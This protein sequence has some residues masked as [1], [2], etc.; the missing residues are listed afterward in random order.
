MAT[1]STILLVAT[2]VKF[3]CKRISISISNKSSLATANTI[4][5]AS[6]LTVQRLLIK[7]GRIFSRNQWRKSSCTS[8]L[9]ARL[10]LRKDMSLKSTIKAFAISNLTGRLSMEL[11]TSDARSLCPKLIFS[12]MPSL[13]VHLCTTL[14]TSLKCIC[15]TRLQQ[16]AR[17]G[18]HPTGRWTNLRK[19]PSATMK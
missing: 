3:T 7:R 18:T 14:E 15:L 4:V 2:K 9:L 19:T 1:T 12:L 17:T 13:T 10:F 8:G 5:R 11:H 16:V 6:R